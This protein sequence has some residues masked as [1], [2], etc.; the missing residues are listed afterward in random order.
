MT[1]AQTP[2][3]ALCV[4]CGTEHEAGVNGF[5][6]EDCRQN[7]HTACRIWGEEQYGAGEVSVFQLRT[8]LGRR[9]WR[10]RHHPASERTKAPETG[11]RA[12]GTLRAAAPA[13]EVR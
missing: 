8:C 3:A 1:G 12:D 7:F 10:T 6:S 2:E 11:T 13:S 9:A 4:W 5:C